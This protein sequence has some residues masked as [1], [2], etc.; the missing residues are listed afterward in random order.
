MAS[1]RTEEAEW[2]EKARQGDDFSFSLLV[3]VYQKPVYNLCYRMLGNARDAEDAA[4]ETFIRAYKSFQRYDPTRKFSTW[5]L[6]IASNYCIDQHRRR[7]LPTFSY[8]G[9]PVPDL[10]EK[11]PGMEHLIMDNEQQDQ[12]AALLER[13]KPVD[14]AAV[15][16]RYWY[17]YSYVE[18]AEALSVTDSAVKSRLHRAR[19]DLA[20]EWLALQKSVRSPERTRY[21]TPAF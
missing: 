15:I 7:K 17:D 13:L 3:E 10:P 14:R 11:K 21:E 20:E 6:T 19:R 5:L 8:D 12:I 16:L 2:L 9:L 18:I 4:Q 1:E